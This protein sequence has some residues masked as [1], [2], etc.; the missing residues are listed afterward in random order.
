MCSRLGRRNLNGNPLDDLQAGP[1]ERGQFVRI[2]RYHPYLTK[3]KV[4]KNLSA[5]L[6]ITRVNRKAKFFVC[7]DR[8]GP[9]ILERIRANLVDDAYAPP[10]LLLVDDRTSAL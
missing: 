8:I 1:F 3:P 7:F 4:E 5:L 9:M 10:F 6:I 2:I